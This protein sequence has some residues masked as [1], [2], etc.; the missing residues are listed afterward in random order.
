MNKK[1]LIKK[2]KELEEKI[3]NREEE[4]QL[5]VLYLGQITSLC[6]EQ[7]RIEPHLTTEV[8]KDLCDFHTNFN[9]HAFTAYFNKV[10]FSKFNP[11]LIKQVEFMKKWQIHI[12]KNLNPLYKIQ[13]KLIE[14]KYDKHK[15]I[16]NYV[17]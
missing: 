8:E 2:V 14:D 10:Y 1:I 11:K 13:K 15:K 6:L 17:S 12:E 4:H 9:V 7:V 5:L 16:P 3:K